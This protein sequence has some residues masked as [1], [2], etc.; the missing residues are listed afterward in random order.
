MTLTAT[1]EKYNILYVDD[2]PSNLRI[3]KDTFRRSFN[4][5]IATSAKEGIQILDNHNIDLIISDQRMPEMTGV[6][7]LKYSF[8][9]YPK[10]NRI[11]LTGYSDIKAI[12]EAINQ[13][14]VFQYVQKPWSEKSLLEIIGD[15]LRVQ[16]LEE[17]NERQKEALKIAKEKAEKSDQ[18]KTEFIYN[19]THEIRTPMNGIIGFASLLENDDIDKSDRKHYLKIIQNSTSQLLRIIDDILEISQLVTKQVN[20][21]KSEF[22]L[23]DLLKELHSLFN[24]KIKDSKLQLFL[25]CDSFNTDEVIT[26]DRAR[27]YT[28]LSNLLDNAIKFTNEGHIELSCIKE[29]DTIKIFVR[30]TGIG[31]PENSIQTIFQRFSQAE[32]DAVNKSGGLGLGLSIAQEN[33]KLINGELSVESKIGEG[34]TF[35]LTLLQK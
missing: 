24:L 16:E 19:L 3:F 6:E 28:I 35:C 29:N 20:V 12:E 10:T 4:I 25:N 26:T 23:N 33:A 2:E 9:K 34:S 5:H 8:Q 27:L 17:E 14:R 15:A 31:I 13:A 11:L 30:D 18:L 1:M 7:L 21:Q 22:N 32:K